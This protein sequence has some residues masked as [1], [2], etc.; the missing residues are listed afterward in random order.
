ML[1]QLNRLIAAEAAR[2]DGPVLV[3]LDGRSGTGKSTVAAE[4]AALHQGQVIAADD[5]WSGADPGE[6]Q[7]LTP[8]ERADVCIDWRR[9]RRVVLEPLCSG[10]T[11]RWQ[12]FN[13]ETGAG[14]SDHE[15]ICPPVPVVVVD[16]V[17]SARPELAELINISVLVTLEDRLRKVRLVRREGE[18]YMTRWHSLWD[19][20]ED[21]YFA[22]V[23][24]PES[25]DVVLSR[26]VN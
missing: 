5:F 16:G 2:L 10:R 1:K 11:A 25:F 8:A 12:T 26:D 15:L 6:L 9:L 21:Y 22:S 3:A 18:A 24:P 23:R 17:Y 4:I 13:W 20:A 19:P 14:L 7:R